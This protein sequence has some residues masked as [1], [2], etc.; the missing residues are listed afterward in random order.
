MAVLNAN[1]ASFQIAT[2][3]IGPYCNSI[4]FSRQNDVVDVSTF[5][6]TGHKYTAT[7]TDGAID[8][9]G[10]WDKTAVVGSYTV[11]SAQVG[12]LTGAAFIYGPEGSATGKV[13]YS[14]TIIM[15]TYAESAPVADVVRFTATFKISGA[16]TIATF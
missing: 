14:G 7:L 16:V 5:G 2:N 10:V 12:A 15:D 1:N 13:K 6:N 4:T 3:E 11:L 9:A 8:I